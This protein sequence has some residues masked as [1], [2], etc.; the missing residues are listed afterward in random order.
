MGSTQKTTTGLPDKIG[1]QEMSS[2][3]QD[4]HLFPGMLEQVGRKKFL[5]LAATA[6]AANSPLNGM[7]QWLET[8]NPTIK[9]NQPFL[10]NLLHTNDFHSRIEAFPANHPQAGKGGIQ[11]LTTLIQKQRTLPT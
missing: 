4:K 2:D 6:A 5:L 10:L 7:T 9:N 1:G 8:L 3:S 11:Q